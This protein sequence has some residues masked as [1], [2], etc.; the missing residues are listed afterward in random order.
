MNIKTKIMISLLS[1]AVVAAAVTTIVLAANDKGTFVGTVTENGT[2][3]PIVGVSVTDGR[4]VVKTNEKGGFEINGWR[5]RM[6]SGRL[7]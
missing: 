5:N 3:N 4:N 2:N 7:R 6:R 1:V